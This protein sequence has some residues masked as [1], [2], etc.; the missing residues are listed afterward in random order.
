ML[1]PRR[2]NRPTPS[3]QQYFVNDVGQDRINH[4]LDS[5]QSNTKMKVVHYDN[6]YKRLG[7]ALNGIFDVEENQSRNSYPAIPSDCGNS[8]VDFMASL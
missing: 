1:L 7:Y 8:N 2:Y 6:I 5:R 3:P 4:H